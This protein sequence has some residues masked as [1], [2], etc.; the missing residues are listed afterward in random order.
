VNPLQPSIKSA[1]QSFFSLL[2]CCVLVV[3]AVW[4][5]YGFLVCLDGL[6]FILG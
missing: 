5:Y 1:G 6:Y 2:L 4:D 3:V